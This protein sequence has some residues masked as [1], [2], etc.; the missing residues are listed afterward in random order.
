MEA[1]HIF[2]SY[3]RKDRFIAETIAE[4]INDWGY[5][6]WMDQISISGGSDWQEKIREGI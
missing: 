2:V 6:V 5:P 4:L 1:R 3:Q